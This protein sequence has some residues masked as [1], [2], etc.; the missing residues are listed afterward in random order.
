[1]NLHAPMTHRVRS[2][3][4]RC[5]LRAIATPTL[6]SL[7]VA[8]PAS[9]GRLL[10]N[11]DRQAEAARPLEFRPASAFDPQA[12]QRAM[13]PG[14]GRVRGVLFH[15]LNDECRR[16]R[17][18]LA[19]RKRADAGIELSLFPATPHLVEYVDLLE[20]HR[21][22]A[23]PALRN[24]FARAP[25]GKR[26]VL[27]YDG[28]MLDYGLSAKTDEFGRYEFGN[29]RPG[30]YWVNADA[31]LRCY[32]NERVQVGSSEVA[33]NP[34]A[35]THVDHYVTEQRYWDQPLN[36]RLFIDIRAD[37]EVVELDSELMPAPVKDTVVL[38][39]EKR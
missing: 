19:I 17:G 15:Q 31:S 22:K 12:A 9:A 21:Y 26:E 14:T 33:D 3:S 1:M 8:L 39:A 27:F 7:L 38:Q 36:Y 23:T 5:G 2:V 4:I 35:P 24:P 20:A 16:T 10:D 30:R 25:S 37:G 6:L 11:A 18:L 29:L 34:Y 32:Y 13:Q 28:R